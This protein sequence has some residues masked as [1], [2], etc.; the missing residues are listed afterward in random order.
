[1]KRR[2]I[3]IR[4]KLAIAAETSARWRRGAR[5][6]V[7]VHSIVFVCYLLLPVSDPTTRPHGER[8]VQCT[9]SVSL[10]GL[11]R[12]RAAGARTQRGALAGH[13]RAVSSRRRPRR[14]VV[15]VQ[16]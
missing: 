2:Q 12:T 13:V 15:F 7:Q 3:R 16:R 8:W 14:R 1:M 5:C 11:R 6:S 9:R 10:S 4:E